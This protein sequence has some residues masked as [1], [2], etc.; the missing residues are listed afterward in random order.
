[1]HMPKDTPH[2][3]EKIVFGTDND[4]IDV[5]IDRYS[6]LMEA[7]KVPDAVRAKVFSQTIWQKLH[8]K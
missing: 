4:P 6:K 1:M 7:C 5:A 8:R 2:A 3:F